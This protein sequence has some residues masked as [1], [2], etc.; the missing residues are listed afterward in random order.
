VPEKVSDYTGER[1]LLTPDEVTQAV[2]CIADPKS[3]EYEGGQVAIRRDN[4]KARLADTGIA[5]QAL[6]VNSAGFDGV[7]TYPAQLALLSA[8]LPDTLIL[9]PIP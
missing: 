5:V 8:E 3:C 7:R 6:P 9:N 1:R 2:T 4:I